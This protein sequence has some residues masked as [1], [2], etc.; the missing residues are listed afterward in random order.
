M[1]K[2]L[3]VIFIA[4]LLVILV[5]KLKDSFSINIGPKNTSTS[6]ISANPTQNQN[7]NNSLTK[8]SSEGPVTV[9][10]TPQ[11]L[12]SSSSTW[13]FDISLNT[14]S[15][16]LSQDLVAASEIVDDQGKSYRPISWEGA[17]PGGHHREG[18]LKFSP[19]SP[20]P[21]FIEIKIKNVGG[22]SERRFKWNL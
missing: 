12:D 3:A 13:N 2:K 15:E 22:V 17:P 7:S 20:K 10:V 4:I 6:T 8:E 14:H 11:G 1:M 21:K 18:V 5:I 9:A 19:I 16:E